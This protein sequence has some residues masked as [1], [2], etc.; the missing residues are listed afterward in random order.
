MQR[1]MAEGGSFCVV[2]KLNKCPDDITRL[3]K[4]LLHVVVCPLYYDNSY[5]YILNRNPC[6]VSPDSRQYKILLD[7]YQLKSRQQLIIYFQI[8]LPS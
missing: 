5:N 3:K 4:L 7:D 2:F 8:Q 1:L 6:I